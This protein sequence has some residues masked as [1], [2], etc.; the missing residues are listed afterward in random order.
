MQKLA[1]IFLIGAALVDMRAATAQDRQACS[2]CIGACRYTVGIRALNC[3]TNLGGRIGGSGCI[4]LPAGA[5]DN[6]AQCRKAAVD[7]EKVCESNC[8]K[9]VC[10]R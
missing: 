6:F 8:R 5:V 4:G 1:M 3:C 10:R 7:Y 2:R 9:D